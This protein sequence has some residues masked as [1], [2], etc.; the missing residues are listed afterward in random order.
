[1][2]AIIVSENITVDGA[3]ED[4]TGEE[5]APGGGWFN[6]MAPAD[7]EAFGRAAL[8]EALGAEA[9]LMGRRT[10][11]FL[12]S[13]WPARTG[14]LADR[15]NGIDK[16]VVS[17]TLRDPSWTNTTVIQGD[18]VAEVAALRQRVGGTIV[19]PASFRLART[20]WE[21]DL[22]DGLTLMVFPV[23]LGTGSALFGQSVG[24]ASLRRLASHR[25]GDGLTHTRYE[26]ARAG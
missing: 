26:T 20:L 19:V 11:D 25:L 12:A 16:H 8:E 10:Y 15:L 21:H 24:S 6:R 22:V 1:M 7:R 13:R 23:L 17:A 18:P 4:P 2:G 3:V 5:G 14:A 9:F